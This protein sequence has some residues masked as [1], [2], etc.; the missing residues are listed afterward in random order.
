MRTH[1]IRTKRPRMAPARR[2]FRMCGDRAEER[3]GRLRGKDGVVLVTVLVDI[4]GFLDLDLRRS[5]V[6]RIGTIGLRSRVI[7]LYDFRVGGEVQLSE[8]V[9]GALMSF[10]MIVVVSKENFVSAGE[11][12]IGGASLL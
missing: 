11:R 10:R 5:L 8:K 3:A 1:E 9:I 2:G 4:V 12:L 7:E 6:R